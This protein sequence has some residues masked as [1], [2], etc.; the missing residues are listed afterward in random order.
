MDQG[1]I[2]KFISEVRKSKKLTQKNLAD[3]L[4]ISEKNYK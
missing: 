2:G 1:K 4:F 3:K